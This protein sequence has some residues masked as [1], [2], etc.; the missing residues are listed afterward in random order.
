MA[1]GRISPPA[2]GGGSHPI[3]DPERTDTKKNKVPRALRG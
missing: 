3:P 1:E 2:R